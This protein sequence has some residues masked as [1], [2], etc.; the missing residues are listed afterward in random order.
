L[1]HLGKYEIVSELGRGGMGVVYKARDP[2]L[3]RLVALKTL[4]PN[5]L[6]RPDLLER[7]LQ[8]ARSAGTLQHPHIVIIYELGEFGPS[9]YIAMEFIEGETLESIIAR[10]APIPLA[11]KLGYIVQASEALQY[12]HEHGVVHRDVK[13][14]NI[15]LNASGFA[16]LVDFGIARVMDSS[17]TQTNLV[18]GSRAY[19][20]PE[21][22]AGHR[23]DART[24]IWALGV[25]LF[26]LLTYRKPFY[27]DTEA[28]VMYKVLKTDAPPVRQV[29]PECP[30]ALENALKRMLEKPVAA[31][32]QNME[33]V[34][35]EL[36]AV[37]RQ[38][39][40]ESVRNLLTEA[41]ARFEARNFTGARDSLSK[42]L[43]IDGS[44]ANARKLSD[45]VSKE[46]LR[47]DLLPRQQA[48]LT[49]ARNQLEAGRL[50]EARAAAEAAL[51]MDP[52]H[53]GLRALLGE[54]AEAERR[55]EALRQDLRIARQR[56]VEGASTEAQDILDRILRSNPDEPGAAELKKQI[57]EERERREWRKQLAAAREKARKLWMQSNY[58]ECLAVLDHELK[59]FPGDPDLVK[60]RE[61]TQQDLAEEEKQQRLTFARK[62][63]GQQ[64]FAQA[65]AILDELG[66]GH[67]GDAS[68]KKLR[69]LVKQGEE[70]LNQRE[71]LSA[72]LREVRGL[73]RQEKYA[74][75]V[76]LG[77]ASV[78]E[79]SRDH[80]LKELVGYARTE[81]TQRQLVDKESD[82]AGHIQ[83]LLGSRKY[84]EAA[85]AAREAIRGFPGQ[86][87]F[88]DLLQE[89]EKNQKDYAI[90]DEYQ[91]RIREIQRR[92]TRQELTDAI[93]M[94][95]QTLATMGPN[96][97]VS[98]L[99]QAARIEQ[100]ERTQRIQE[101]LNAAET[102]VVGG[103]INDATRLLNDAFAT[104]TLQPS[105]PGAKKL[106]DRIADLST[107]SHVPPAPPHG[108][109]LE[110]SAQ[111]E[112]P[113]P[114]LLPEPV[115][116]SATHVLNLTPP[117]AA[118]DSL[119]PGSD[120]SPLSPPSAPQ[121][122]P[123][124]PARRVTARRPWAFR[125]SLAALGARAHSIG[126]SIAATIAAIGTKL[127][128]QELLS[129]RPELKRRSV[130]AA[131]ATILAL[132][133]VLG[134]IETW[135]HYRKLQ[136]Q[137]WT[138]N[139][140]RRDAERAWA[141]H[142][143]DPA[144]DKWRQ[145][146]ALHGALAEK[147]AQEISHIESQ[148]A[149]EQQLFD[150]GN[151][152]IQADPKDSKGRDELR[153]I[154]AR[155]LWHA[156]AAQSA[157]DS[158]QQLD[159][160]GHDLSDKEQ[161]FF[162]QGEQFFDAKNYDA[163]RRQFL[164]ALNLE[165]PNSPLR[166]KVL[167]FLGKIRALND[168]K[169]NYEI[170]SQDIQNEDW[171]SARDG[172]QSIVGHRGALKDDA[173]KQLDKVTSIQTALGETQE[174]IRSRS[175]RAAKSKL[176][177]IQPWPK[178]YNRLR[179]ELSSAE[180]QELGSIKSRAATLAQ[181]QDA[182]GLE[183]L[184]T[185]LDNFSGRVTDDSVLAATQDLSRT[186]SSQISG[187]KKDQ[188]GDKTA[189]EKAE[190][191]FQQAR[192]DADIHRINTEIT[193]EFQQ[194]AQGNGYNRVAA[195]S[196]LS[197]VI[198]GTVKELTENLAAKG[199][200]VVPPISCNL[201]QAEIQALQTKVRNAI[202]C[203]DVDADSPLGWMGNPVVDLPANAKSSGKL[204]YTLHLIVVVNEAGAVIHVDKDGPADADFLK[205]AK[206]SAKQWKTTVP[207]VNK[208]PASAAFPV[209]V[210]F[211]P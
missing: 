161:R 62:L 166:P 211:Q 55:K 33:E 86:A 15:M 84:R 174:L 64:Q 115:Q 106:L 10:R 208:K 22:Y 70:E 42:A 200:A 154:V 32:Y 77:T 165:T 152:L 173:Q 171:Q 85:A 101:T 144:E 24:D 27:S 183:R 75:A 50:A 94:A 163:A 187:L 181:S 59:R 176:D 23:A 34:T 141:Q 175:Y 123:V 5:V 1:Q 41:R 54:I 58:A 188:S 52:R 56:I 63:L 137:S 145:V 100:E 113:K 35:S 197:S 65:M 66:Q 68:V 87:R 148:R 120:A 159:Q 19:M 110:P 99:L 149:D 203:A 206:E 17:M 104:K 74:E 207:L 18:L 177:G 13:P 44:D 153:Q 151:R 162:D 93:D 80:E 76:E 194:I 73:I 40:H 117:P 71:R 31:R 45:E 190:R 202:I 178:S 185:E 198:P 105:H 92:I 156:A 38:L 121:R 130:M 36:G 108:G 209:A 81:L 8:E 146:E 12:A 150:D 4:I 83:G 14:G 39:Q 126:Q 199:R 147:A 160:S 132:A 168:D 16:K 111:M 91:Q 78:R 6:G 157:L 29:C 125:A 102:L 193:A 21:I 182:E 138:E 11:A 67:P 28:G 7:F 20:A 142:N 97:Q 51:A 136:N 47:V 128:V 139:Q 107:V 158:L 89:A 112:A 164:D 129:V 189:F 116:S 143:P 37:W 196:Y 172:F 3:N 133:T 210:T 124:R 49:A 46:I 155:Q 118:A 82:V 109:H 57:Q 205:K 167:E 127:R 186:L 60:L 90:R 98:Q 135:L 53:E 103:R 191:D 43:Q 88:K 169:K 114:G 48:Q 72:A 96:Q 25:T 134:G 140:L 2:V 122:E 26:E 170:A 61:T 192:S 204:P 119:W 184:Q 79:F 69:E 9:P 95:Q 201:T 179:D 195:Q 30:E 180:Q 131:T